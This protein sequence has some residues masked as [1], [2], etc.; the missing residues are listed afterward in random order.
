MIREFFGFQII[1]ES[2]M[3]WKYNLCFVNKI[4]TK[5]DMNNFFERIFSYTEQITFRQPVAF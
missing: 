5:L 4:S 3:K 2:I 1:F